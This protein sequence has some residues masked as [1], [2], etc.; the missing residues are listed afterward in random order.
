[1]AAEE[2]DIDADDDSCHRDHV[3]HARERSSHEPS[4]LGRNENRGARAAAGGAAAAACYDETRIERAALS[5]RFDARS[6]V[7][8]NE[9]E[10]FL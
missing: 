5:R 4:L 9:R 6:R 1:V 8:I 10:T 2:Q 7:Q 3:E